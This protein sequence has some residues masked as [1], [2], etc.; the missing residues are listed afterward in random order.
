MQGL[1][2]E[3]P[4]T[5]E[6]GSF[7][8]NY[9]A[10]L[11]DGIHVLDI[12]KQQSEELSGMLSNLDDES[13]LY[14]YR[15]GKWSIKEVLGHL[16]DTERIFSFRALSIARGEKTELPGFDHD[17]YV[18]LAEFDSAGLNRLT[19]E[20]SAVRASTRLMFMGFNEEMLIR[21]GVANQAPCTVRALAFIIAGHERHHIGLLRN[22]Y[23]LRA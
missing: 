7:Y 19:D 12:L 13:A 8:H 4:E 18:A 17:S 10:L 6:Y 22:R 20:Y 1:L 11:P 2:E 16:T 14:R 21:Q 15:P 23:G 5:H 9:I 3:K